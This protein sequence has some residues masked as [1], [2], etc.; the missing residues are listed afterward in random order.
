MEARYNAF[1][2]QKIVKIV[3]ISCRVKILIVCFNF[4]CVCLLLHVNFHYYI[5]VI[6][7][8]VC[9]Y[10]LSFFLFNNHLNFSQTP[11]M[12][13]KE[14]VL[15][16]F[17]FAWS[18]TL[19]LFVTLFL[20]VGAHFSPVRFWAWALT[21]LEIYSYVSGRSFLSDLTVIIP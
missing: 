12:K 16:K 15:G 17:P 21:L 1:L 3:F 6:T 9:V 13:S 10:S 19:L 4:S 18:F 2:E 14:A 11:E 8:F 5:P 7:F 20:Y